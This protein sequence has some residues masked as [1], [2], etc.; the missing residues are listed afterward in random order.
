MLLEDL[1]PPRRQSRRL[2]RAV[3][4]SVRVVL[5]SLMGSGFS[6]GQ[7]IRSSIPAAAAVED[8]LKAFVM[9]QGL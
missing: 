7:E 5:F 2:F 9:A 8:E 6:L 3:S 1:T 4:R